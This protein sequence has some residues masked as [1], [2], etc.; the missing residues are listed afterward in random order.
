MNT[1]IM[2]SVALLAAFCAVST[3]LAS[4]D[5]VDMRFEGTGKGRNVRVTDGSRQL[6]VF[7]GQLRHSFFNG[8]GLGAQLSGEMITYCTD[9]SQY[10]SSTTRSY[11]VVPVQS[12][13]VGIAMGMDKAR[14]IASLY[15]YAM[16]VQLTSSTSN[17]LGAAFQLAVWEVVSDFDYNLGASSLNL[18][19]GNFRATQTN[20]SAVWSSVSNL[21]NGFFA[22]TNNS[23][24]SP[25]GL[26]AIAS[27]S[28]Q[29][30]LVVVP[31]PGTGLLAGLG[32]ALIAK[33]TRRN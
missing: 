19:T 7:A 28:Y 32:M 17:D 24:F 2:K 4:A 26:R 14:A 21:L 25:S 3:G 33:R 20:G 30:Q 31:A 23:S 9:L 18:S 11:T 8:T 16:G 29:D 5:T 10:V 12:A 6:N 1:R 27:G 13:P 22:H 15:D